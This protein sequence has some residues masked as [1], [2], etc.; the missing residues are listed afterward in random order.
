MA[1]DSSVSRP[2]FFEDYVSGA[3]YELGSVH[4]TAEDIV[5]FATQFD[6][7]TFHVDEDGAQTTVFGGLIASGWHTVSLYMRL[8]VDGLLGTSRALGSPGSDELSWPHP[9]RPGDTLRARCTIERARVSRSDPGRG[10][11]STCGEM[12]NQRDEVVMRLRAA[13]LIAR[14]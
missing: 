5:A 12:I 14:R 11:V 8:F 9:V 4:V 13:V 2:V 3:V 6:P 10:V 1:V 7:Q